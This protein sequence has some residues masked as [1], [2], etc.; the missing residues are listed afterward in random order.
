VHELAPVDVHY[1]WPLWVGKRWRCE[2]VDR[3]ANGPTLR[4]QASYVVEALE[5]IEVPAGRFEALRILRCLRL[6]DGGDDYLTRTQV[7]WYAPELGTELR[8]VVADTMVELVEHSR[9]Q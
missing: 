7:C 5:T 4:L 9:P 1:H 2:F 6:V 8:Q 3:A